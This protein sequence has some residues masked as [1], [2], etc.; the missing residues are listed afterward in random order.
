M[1]VRQEVDTITAADFSFSIEE[2]VHL[3][4]D[5]LNKEI[6]LD[7]AQHLAD[8]TEGWA[9]ALVLLADRVQMSRT[10]ISLEQ[11]RGSDTLFQYIK[12]EQFDPLPRR[13]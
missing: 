2:V 13:R 12:L 1:S 11:L 4:R 9:A 6:S 7:D 5:V 3:F 8:V 10:S